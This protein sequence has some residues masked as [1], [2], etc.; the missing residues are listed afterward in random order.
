MNSIRPI[1]LLDDIVPFFI[2]IDFDSHKLFEIVQVKLSEANPEQIISSLVVDLELPNGFKEVTLS[3]IET[4]LLE[5]KKLTEIYPT[6]KWAQEGSGIHIFEIEASTNSIVYSDLFDWDIF[7]Y[8]TDPD[9]FAR[10]TIKELGL[11][12]ELIN[13]L[14]G[15]IRWHTIKLRIFHSNP[16]NLQKLI[17]KNPN[18]NPQQMIGLRQVT[19]LID[20]SPAIGIIPGREHKSTTSSRNRDIRAAR[21]QGRSVPRGA[22]I[23]IEEGGIIQIK[24]VPTVRAMIMPEDSP[25]VDLNAIPGL[26]KESDLIDDQFI[27]RVRQKMEHNTYLYNN[28][29]QFSDENDSSGNEN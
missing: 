20:V 26:L 27:E 17:I 16:E 24:L 18:F 29:N 23:P 15:Q 6:S 2:N 1:L 28:N 21:R 5:Y 12:L 14:S 3:F 10:L 19:E 4:Q 13:S 7:D 11:P 22:L 9:D 25:Y 8:E